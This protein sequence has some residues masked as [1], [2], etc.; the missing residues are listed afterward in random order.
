[1]STGAGAEQFCDNEKSSGMQGSTLGFGDGSP[2]GSQDPSNQQVNLHSD[3]E[4]VASS[5][6]GFNK[7]AVDQTTEI[8]VSDM[9]A[10]IESS[11][12]SD[13]DSIN[14]DDNE[15]RVFYFEVTMRKRNR[16]FT[17]RLPKESF[18]KI[19][20]HFK[21]GELYKLLTQLVPE[22]IDNGNFSIV[23]DLDSLEDTK[24][25]DNY[26]KQFSG[27]EKGNKSNG[28]YQ[29]GTKFSDKICC[30][31]LVICIDIWRLPTSRLQI[32]LT[33]QTA[34]LLPYTLFK[35]VFEPTEYKKIPEMIECFFEILTEGWSK[36]L[37]HW[38]LGINELDADWNRI[39]NS[40]KEFR[41]WLSKYKQFEKQNKCPKQ[42]SSGRK[43]AAT[44]SESARDLERYSSLPEAEY[45]IKSG[46]QS[47]VFQSAG[48]KGEED[49]LI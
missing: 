7:T 18:E 16:Q 19:A 48:K 22:I 42:K 24:G 35:E 47:I 40:R 21:F 23:A 12:S 28:E 9:Q 27:W 11:K 4:F 36:I 45:Q 32:N 46:L 34:V 29:S 8:G 1:M 5:K 3:R 13:S 33:L 49:T 39:K 41:T 15:F 26:R 10:L 14:S 43:K 31:K 30:N 38:M 37:S 25:R 44:K 20:Q 17:C 6:S 2:A